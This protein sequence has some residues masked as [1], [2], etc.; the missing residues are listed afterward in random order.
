[1]VAFG[2]SAVGVSIGVLTYEV[3]KNQNPVIGL[4]AAGSL[5]VISHYI[6]DFIPHGHF[7]KFGELKKKLYSIIFFDLILSITLFLGA[8]ILAQGLSFRLLYILF[9]MG[10]AL[11]PDAIDAL[12]NIGKLPYKSVLKFEYDLQ[13]TAHWHGA[14]EKG[15]PI[16]IWDIWQLGVVVFSLWL[17]LSL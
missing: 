17:I 12:I 15:L 13:Q 14:K 5:G 6:C 9:G 1:M 7:V 10:G 8:E 4:V 11:F 3:L 16:G 2:H